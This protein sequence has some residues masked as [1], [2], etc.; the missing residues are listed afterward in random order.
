MK[1]TPEAK[2]VIETA[3]KANNANVVRILAVSSDCCGD[4][5]EFAIG[6]ANE[7]DALDVIEGISFLMDEKAKKMTETVILSAEGDELFMS[8]ENSCGCGAHGDSG[9]SCGEDE[10]E[11]SCGDHCEDGCCEGEKD[12]CE[13]GC[14]SK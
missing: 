13:C 4:S 9:C 1:I 5:L 3:L 14:H 7:G 10:K 11:C 8:D 6:N 12:S 2:V